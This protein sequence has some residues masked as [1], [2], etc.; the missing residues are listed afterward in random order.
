MAGSR[1]T[2]A[3]TSS[4][5]DGG[6]GTA[7]QSYGRLSNSSR[8]WTAKSPEPWMIGRTRI[9]GLIVRKSSAVTRGVLMVPLDARLSEHSSRQ[10]VG[11]GDPA[12]LAPLDH[13]RDVLAGLEVLAGPISAWPRVGVHLD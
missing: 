9:R 6:N 1:S 4:W 11:D 8:T 5:N 3:S 7:T 10:D 13:D 12:D 2:A